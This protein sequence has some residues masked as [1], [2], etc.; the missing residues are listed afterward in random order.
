MIRA[1]VPERVVMEITGHCTRSTFDRYN[2][3]SA[4]DRKQAFRKVGEYV[5]AKA[6]GA[7]S[8]KVVPLRCRESS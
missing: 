6:S 7:P 5:K 1:C 2:I 3:T 4:E 8:R